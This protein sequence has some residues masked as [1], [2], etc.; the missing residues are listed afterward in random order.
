MFKRKF[1]FAA[2]LIG[3]TQSGLAQEENPWY[4]GLGGGTSFGQST[5]SSISEDGIHSW[6]IQGGLFGG[7]KLNRLISLEAGFQYGKQNEFNQDCCPYWLST[8]GQWKATQV[9]DMDGWYFDDMKVATRWYRMALQANFNALSFVKAN[10]H[11]S[12]D[13]S[14][15]ISAVN[16]K[17][18]WKGELS[19]GQGYHQETQSSDWH[20]G[21]GGQIGAGYAFDAHW[22]L[23]IYGGITAVIGK[24]FDNIPNKVHKANNIW[25]AGIKVSYAFGKKKQKDDAAALAATAAA[26]TAEAERL[27]A[28]KAAQ[29]KAAQEAAA[30]AAK[31][32]AAKEA[33]ARA[34]QEKAAQEAAAREKAERDAQEA[35]K[36]YHGTFSNIYFANNSVRLLNDE[37][38]KLDE[39]AQ[40]LEQHP[41]TAIAL[42]GY[43]SK[44]GGKKHNLRISQKRVDKVKAY[45]MEKGIDGERINPVEG[46]GVDDS[47]KFYKDARRVEI[48]VVEK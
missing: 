21:L 45:L 11:W 33:A 18:T 9:I 38:A 2:I 34:A 30:R 12:L 25:D 26:A 1:F 24:R 31:E 43:A 14:P 42:Y 8:D 40:L 19:K 27:A 47:V 36:Y 20:L 23:G 29:E 39:V 4:V 5:F 17:S 37:K 16:T 10:K 3:I 44:T 6:G 7:Y 13:L 28:E 22:K 48:V 41:N 15:Q 32:K 46:K 35:A